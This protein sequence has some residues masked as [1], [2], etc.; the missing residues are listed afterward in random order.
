LGTGKTTVVSREVVYHNAYFPDNP[1]FANIRMSNVRNYQALRDVAT[2]FEIDEACCLLLDEAW[3]IADSRKSMVSVVNDVMSMFMIRSRKKNW[4]VELTEQLH[5]QLDI[6]LRFI[7]D[8]WSQPRYYDEIDMIYIPYQV[9][10][11]TMFDEDWF[12]PLD[13]FRQGI[14]KTDEDPLTLDVENLKER[15]DVFMRRQ[16]NSGKTGWGDKE[17]QEK[18]KRSAWAARSGSTF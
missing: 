18:L 15:Y 9:G 17:Q 11:G 7:T 6:R 13:M 16:W 5:T 10:E 2:L 8:V 4:W 1:V 12:D 3:H 14:F